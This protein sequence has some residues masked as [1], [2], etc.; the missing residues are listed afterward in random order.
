[1][2]SQ[3]Y[4]CCKV[5]GVDNRQDL[6]AA[7]IFDLRIR[8]VCDALLVDQ[9]FLDF[10]ILLNVETYCLKTYLDYWWKLSGELTRSY[11]L[12]IDCCYCCSCH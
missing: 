3:T 7:L 6:L 10:N 8:Y 12:A 2:S 9:K 5:M 4:H 1:M 11:R